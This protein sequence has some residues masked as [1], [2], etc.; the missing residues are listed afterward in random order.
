MRDVANPEVIV[1]IG[2]LLTFSF[3]TF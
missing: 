1:K 3:K 2:T